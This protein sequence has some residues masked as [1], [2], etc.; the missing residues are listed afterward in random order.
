LVDFV[1]YDSERGTIT[2]EPDIPE[3]TLVTMLARRGA[4]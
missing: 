4:L 3:S 2:V 1:E